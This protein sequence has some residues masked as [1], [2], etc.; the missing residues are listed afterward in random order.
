MAPGRAHPGEHRRRRHP[1][2]A[3]PARRSLLVGQIGVVL[4][5]SSALLGQVEGDR[6]AWAADPHT[7]ARSGV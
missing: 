1:G 3:A 7:P 4:L 5:S 6:V 2:S